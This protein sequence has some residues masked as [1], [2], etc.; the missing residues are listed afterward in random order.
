MP[1]HAVLKNKHL[2]ADSASLDHTGEAKRQHEKVYAI[3]MQQKQV[4]QRKNLF[5]DLVCTGWRGAEASDVAEAAGPSLSY[6]LGPWAAAAAQWDSR[7]SRCC[8]FRTSAQKGP[9]GPGGGAQKEDALLLEMQQLKQQLS[10]GEVL[11]IAHE[12]QWLQTE[13]QWGWS[14]RESDM[15]PLDE[16]VPPE[17]SYRWW[18]KNL[19]FHVGR[20][21]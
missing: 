7:E 19:F 1:V 9:A 16:S 6:R 8:F 18:R 20:K 2:W 21:F 13:T 15:T 14:G 17:Q 12:I 11:W 5:P 4:T 10:A 3:K